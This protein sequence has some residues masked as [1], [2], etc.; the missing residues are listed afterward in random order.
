[1][2]YLVAL[3]L[4]SVLLVT[5]GCHAH[6]DVDTHDSDHGVSGSVNTH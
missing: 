4:G 2:K 3:L 5:V 6:G 1:M